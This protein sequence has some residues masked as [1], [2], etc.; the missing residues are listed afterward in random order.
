M[1]VTAK[2]DRIS[3]LKVGQSVDILGRIMGEV[4][5]IYKSGDII[6]VDLDIDPETRLPKNTV[7]VLYQPSF[8][9]GRGITLST[10]DSCMVEPCLSNG[11]T[12]IGEVKTHKE[13]VSGMLDPYLPTINKITAFAISD[14][15]AFDY[16]LKQTHNT[17]GAVKGQTR[18]LNKS[19]SS[20][21][22]KSY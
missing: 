5:A 1:V 17:L 3:F 16:Y 19:L 9:G 13:I 8:L 14:S 4:T 20:K 2:F 22:L 6:Y 11:D 7:A 10:E 12:I 18:K 15:M 21:S